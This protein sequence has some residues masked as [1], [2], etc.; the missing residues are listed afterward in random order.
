VLLVWS[1]VAHGGAGGWRFVAGL[2]ALQV[3]CAG[4]AL[5][6][7]MSRRFP[8]KVPPV[9]T[10]AMQMLFGGA[11]MLAVGTALGD[12][13][14][15]SA[16]WRSSAAVLYLTFVGGL[17]GFA[18]YVYALSRLPVSFVS[19]YAY[20]NPI[21][22]VALGTW[23]LGEPFGP[24]MAVAIVIVL[25]GMALVSSTPRPPGRPAAHSSSSPSAP[26]RSRMVAEV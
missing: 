9:Q 11:W 20:V 16:S 25:A 24:R 12:W 22:A 5:G 15:V 17:A 23:L 21:I 7:S 18:A 14:A 6:S 4:W 19:L 1:D 8:V 13:A 3:A 2:V 10:A 26:D